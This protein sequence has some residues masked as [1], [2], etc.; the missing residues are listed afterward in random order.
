MLQYLAER[1]KT[2]IR[3]IEGAIK[4]LKGHSLINGEEISLEMAKRVLTDFLR[5]SEEDNINADKILKYISLRYGVKKEDI[6]GAKRDA[7]VKNARH[8]SAFLMRDILGL[9]YK[10][11]GTILNKHHSTIIESCQKME[12][13]LKK[14][15][16]FSRE[17]EEIQRELAV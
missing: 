7:A 2:N 1:I 16:R 6:S 9:T 4:T 3:Q 8:I 5:K 10:E 13:K 14:E 11:I 12:E 17:I 15:E